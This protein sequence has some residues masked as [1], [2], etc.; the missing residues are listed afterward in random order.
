MKLS[1]IVPTIRPHNLRELWTSTEKAVNG[2]YPWEMA[3]IGPRDVESG[4]EWV[5]GRWRFIADDGS[6]CH[7][8]QRAL[9]HCR[10]E[11]VTWAA[12]D[13][14]WL[15]GSLDRDWDDDAILCKYMEGRPDL[16][17]QRWQGV[18][19]VT[20]MDVIAFARGDVG[21][22]PDMVASDD[23]WTI[24]YHKGARVSGVTPNANLLLLGIL[25]RDLVLSVGGF[26]EGYETAAQAQIDLGLRLQANG[27]KFMVW[28]HI[29]Q[30]LG[31]EPKAERGPLQGAYEED[32]KRYKHL[33]RE[34]RQ[35]VLPISPD[36]DKPQQWARRVK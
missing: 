12:D 6:P 15:P 29:V 18:D 26:D 36:A 33:W 22:N 24:G 5:G 1:I 2:R 25:K 34:P 9:L 13:G 21:L 30:A 4:A 32:E 23:F 20:R 3:A 16:R 27:T 19:P 14:V 28:Q 11:Y 17:D 8:Q 35:A 10:G 31:Y 7:C